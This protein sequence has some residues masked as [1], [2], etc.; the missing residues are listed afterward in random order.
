V[1]ASP[2]VHCETFL[3]LIREKAQPPQPDLLLDDRPPSI[4]KGTS[5]WDQRYRRLG[6]RSPLEA[7][8][9]IV[10]S[11]PYRG[12]WVGLVKPCVYVLGRNLDRWLEDGALDARA[13]AERPLAAFLA[14]WAPAT[15]R[16]EG[17][18]RPGAHERRIATHYP[19]RSLIHCR[20]STATTANASRMTMGVPSATRR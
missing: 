9:A 3:Q 4:P 6:K 2:P 10:T 5:F 16:D 15:Q 20:P 13:D 7:T 19:S 11:G 1:P 17:L 18:S 14:T 8:I 12:R